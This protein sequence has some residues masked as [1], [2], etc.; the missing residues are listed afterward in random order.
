MFG[1]LASCRRAVSFWLCVEVSEECERGSDGIGVDSG[2]QD[3][4][5]HSLDFCLLWLG[6]WEILIYFFRL[7]SQ[8]GYYSTRSFGTVVPCYYC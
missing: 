4:S 3:I 2:T 1:R 8:G 5:F 7:L 6:V